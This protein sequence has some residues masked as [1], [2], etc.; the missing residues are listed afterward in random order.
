[1]NELNI[2]GGGKM[3]SALLAGI[4]S[5]GLFPE[6]SVVVTEVA[7]E[8]SD[9]VRG[10][11][12]NVEVTAEVV[13]A[14]IYLIAVKPAQ[15][16]ETLGAV[17]RIANPNEPSLVISIAAGVPISKIAEDLG[18]GFEIARVMPNA[19]ATV[20]S[21]VSGVSFAP[22]TRQETRDRV[23]EI[24]R[25]VGSVFELPEYQLDALTALSGSGP[26][27]VYLFMEALEEAGVRLG[28]PL[29][30]AREL[31]IG[32]VGGAAKT[33][34]VSGEDFRK[35][36]LDVTSPAGTTA[37]AVAKLEEHGLRH[38]VLEA[39]LACYQRARELGR[40]VS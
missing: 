27:Y 31:V 7:I 19:A 32:T 37:A 5:E 24:F 1:M 9:R 2:V 11:F 3:G 23:L 26:A 40:P 20:A 18:E 29:A 13:A 28:L 17:R 10:Q 16:S 12:P 8:T 21:A 36:R 4:L 33:A 38:A 15:V 25:G 14:R 6:N 22:E 35:L 30:L 34:L 39:A